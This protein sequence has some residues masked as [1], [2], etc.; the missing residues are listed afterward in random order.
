[1]ATCSEGEVWRATALEAEG[2][3]GDDDGAL[4]LLRLILP[5][6]L[7]STTSL[8][9]ASTPT[10]R[11]WSASC[12]MP[13]RAQGG[14]V[15]G[16]GARVDGQPVWVVGAAAKQE[17][18]PCRRGKKTKLE[19]APPRM[20]TAASV[21]PSSFGWCEACNGCVV[22]VVSAKDVEISSF[23]PGLAATGLLLQL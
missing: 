1:M 4:G 17:S 14:G 12:A 7:L 19:P 3:G 20:R 5:D 15:G 18:E 11:S 6:V 16:K 9:S 10:P 21:C 22:C 8:G 13:V 23:F 2:G